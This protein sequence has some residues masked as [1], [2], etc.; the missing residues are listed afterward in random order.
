MA[1]VAS[2][3]GA[4]G[5]AGAPVVPGGPLS[6]YLSKKT[7]FAYDDD[8]HNGEYGAYAHIG[9]TNASRKF[10]WRVEAFLNK[11]KSRPL[12]RVEKVTLE[13]RFAKPG[14][15]DFFV[16]EEA[17]RKVAELQ[18][19]AFTRSRKLPDKGE[20][21]HDFA[22]FPSHVDFAMMLLGVHTFDAKNQRLTWIK[23]FE[24]LL[25]IGEKG[26]A[27]LSADMAYFDCRNMWR[28]TISVMTGVATS[29]HSDLI[30][31]HTTVDQFIGAAKA[32][33]ILVLPPGKYEVNTTITKP[34]IFVGCPKTGVDGKEE[35]P[36][37]VLR[38]KV[39]V[40]TGGADPEAGDYPLAFAG[41]TVEFAPVSK[42]LQDSE[43]LNAVVCPKVLFYNSKVR[44]E[45][46]T[47]AP[48]L[49]IQIKA[50]RIHIS[51]SYFL[52]PRENAVLDADFIG[53]TES[54]ICGTVRVENCGE[55]L[56]MHQNNI[57]AP[58]VLGGRSLKV[59]GGATGTGT[60]D[61]L[62]F[63]H[64]YVAEQ[65][66]GP[67]LVVHHDAPALPFVESHPL[68][69]P[70]NAV[71]RTY[72]VQLPTRA[73]YGI[74]A[75][76]LAEATII[77][78]TFKCANYKHQ[79]RYVVVN[80]NSDA[81]LDTS[82]LPEYFMVIDTDSGGGGSAKARSNRIAF[83]QLSDQY[84]FCVV[85]NYTV[86]GELHQPPFR[87]VK[88]AAVLLNS[89]LSTYAIP[90]KDIV[91]INASNAEKKQQVM[92]QLRGLVQFATEYSTLNPTDLSQMLRMIQTES[93]LASVTSSACPAQALVA[94]A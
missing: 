58:I 73:R 91:I 72:A 60:D 45:A 1:A 20:L 32:G 36:H 33:D 84:G 5:G 64:N 80:H 17:A 10:L 69:G 15:R 87:E 9:D 75:S 90:T 76:F 85:Y 81:V 11:S 68:Q 6:G 62:V 66:Y 54:T 47:Q 77:P 30:H 49:G 88:T 25:R 56:L 50:Q 19:R 92:Q 14:E 39:A 23:V 89:D 43:S 40:P 46:T 31:R 42:T 53:I 74:M 63:L 82:T 27:C 48:C 35:V 38:S 16:S 93:A 83:N 79:S 86:P 21:L 12:T 44:M 61:R 41:L 4:G 57:S 3:A 71:S 34:L 28:P 8:A 29:L 67:W 7:V 37:L 52:L 94:T 18:L 51:D 26:C 65:I 13:N 24:L 22:P 70:D 59:D 2:R 78:S 55:G